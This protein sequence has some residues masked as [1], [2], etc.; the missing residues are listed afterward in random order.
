MI[1][2][3]GLDDADAPSPAITPPVAP[4]PIAPAPIAPAPIAPAPIG[5]PAPIAGPGSPRS[6]AF[7]GITYHLAYQSFDGTTAI[8]EHIPSGEAPARWTRMVAIRHFTR[9]TVP[10]EIATRINAGLQAKRPPRRSELRSS[11]ADPRTTLDFI[12]YE[13]DIF[14]FN[15]WRFV[16][17][18]SGGVIGY[19]YAWRTYD[20]AGMHAMTAALQRERRAIVDRFEALVLPLP[21]P[22]LP[23]GQQRYFTR[24]NDAN[25]P[26]AA[27]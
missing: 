7:D 13:G 23:A 8:E 1:L 12:D 6:V 2:A 24:T 3:C 27:P 17:H 10:M 19:Q 25:G 20:D 16:P 14:E 9:D 5:Q 22:P 4:A 15:V 11:P 26:V 21:A 18:P